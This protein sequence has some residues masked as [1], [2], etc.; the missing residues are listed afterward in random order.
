MKKTLLAILITA[1]ITIGVGALALPSIQY[2]NTNVQFKKAVVDVASSTGSSGQLFSSTGT[3]TLW[4]DHTIGSL[5]VD[6]LSALTPNGDGFVT[7]THNL[8]LAHPLVQLWNGN[9]LIQNTVDPSDGVYSYIKIVDANSIAVDYTSINSLLGSNLTTLYLVVGGAGPQGPAGPG[10]STSTANYFTYYNDTNSVTGTPLMRF[11]NG[12]IT[13]TTK[14]IF[15]NMIADSLVSSNLY[16]D[17]SNFLSIFTTSINFTTATGSTIT[18]TNAFFTKIGI[19]SSSPNAQLGITGSG[20]QKPLLITSSSGALFLSIDNLGNLSTQNGGF[21]YEASSSISYLA[22]MQTGPLNSENNPGVIFGLN[23]LVTSLSPTGTPH[24]WLFGLNDTG[25]LTVYTESAG[26]GSIKNKRV[27]VNSTTPF[28]SLAVQGEVG[29]DL[30]SFATSTGAITLKIDQY[31]QLLSLTYPVNTTSTISN[32]IIDPPIINATTAATTIAVYSD[33]ITRMLT[34]STA[35]N[36]ALSLKSSTLSPLNTLQTA[37]YNDAGTLQTITAQ[38]ALSIGSSFRGAVTYQG[39]HYAMVVSTTTGVYVVKR[40]TS[41]WSNDLS[42]FANWATTTISGTT[43]TSTHLGIIGAAN[44]NIYI[45]SSSTV[46]SPFS[47]TTSTNTLTAG[48]N[49]TISAATIALV[50]TRVNDNGIYAAFN[51]APFVRKFTL[52]GVTTTPFGSGKGQAAPSG[53]GPDVFTLQRS[54]YSLN[55]TMLFKNVGF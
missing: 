7:S 8:N 45:A 22:S 52:S 15:S 51:S 50:T 10:V 6:N 5:F 17:T 48:A 4:V 21:Y 34:V 55:G 1:G 3:S 36:G 29:S 9:V 32:N 19:N 37:F 41:T 54:Y 11:S 24:G 46:I 25:I 33:D 27:G 35:A 26:G 39:Y 47:I 16:A 14:T 12:A 13:F 31:G 28:A 2:F 44:N 23:G 40:A 30:A 49:V 53:T 43:L 20:T 38:K 42:T 18:S